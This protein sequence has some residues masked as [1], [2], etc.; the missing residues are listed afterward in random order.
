MMEYLRLKQSE[1]MNN[2]FCVTGLDT[3]IYKANPNQAEFDIIPKM[4]V[5][6]FDYAPDVDIP[7]YVKIPTPMVS[8][9]L[10]KV[11][12]MYD[13]NMSFKGV[14]CYPKQIEDVKKAAPLYWTYYCE[15]L[16]CLHS[17]AE[18][19]PN[20]AIMKLVV[21]K[22]KLRGKDIVVIGGIQEKITLVSLAVAESILRRN[23]FGVAFEEIDLR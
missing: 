18:I 6:Y 7:D 12:Q 22:N 1:Q 16:E 23:L 5:T 11:F 21:N 20:G 19:A 14:Q 2:P 4:L 3:G 15:Q 8:E 17:K 9:Q 13:E 10:K